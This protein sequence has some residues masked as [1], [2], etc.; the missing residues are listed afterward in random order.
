MIQM[1]KFK[2]KFIVKFNDF[3]DDKNKNSAKNIQQFNILLFSVPL[4]KRCTKCLP[5][6][7]K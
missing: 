5:V 1:F 6:V 2:P 4:T 7:K 3:S